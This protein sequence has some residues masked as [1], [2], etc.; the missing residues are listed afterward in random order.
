MDYVWLTDKAIEAAKKSSYKVRMGAVIFRG[1]RLISVGHNH[2][3]KAAKHLHPRFQKWPG[4]I[5]AEVDAILKAKTDLRRCNI[6]VVRIN[7]L[8]EIRTSKPCD[9]CFLYLK[10]TGIRKV[11]Y[12]VSGFNYYLEETIL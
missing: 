4:S 11:Y 6:L 7:R 1:K 2:P 3:M 10:L 12:T 5:H 8:G 9:K